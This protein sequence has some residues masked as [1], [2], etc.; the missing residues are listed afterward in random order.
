LTEWFNTA[1]YSQP[2]ADTY[3]N[4]GRNSLFGPHYTDVDF[5]LFR[6]FSF[7]EHYR[8]QF[9]IEAF[10]MFNHPNFGNP[11]SG[12]GDQRFGA[13]TGTSGNPRELQLAGTFKF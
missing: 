5:S 4:V 9:R 6:N 2:L 8:A 1:A 11:D 3:G 13:I 7:L 10:N 12:F